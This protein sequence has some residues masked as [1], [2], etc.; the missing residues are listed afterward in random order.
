MDNGHG[1]HR[2]TKLQRGKWVEEDMAMESIDI[3]KIRIKR[4]LNQR[5]K[6][7][8]NSQMLQH[9]GEQV[10]FLSMRPLGSNVLVENTK[11]W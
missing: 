1:R 7:F 3:I 6:V 8:M 4:N 9:R 2:T 11:E 5:M 10:N